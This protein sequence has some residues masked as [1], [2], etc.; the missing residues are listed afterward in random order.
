MQTHSQCTV[1]G[2]HISFS[3]ILKR[4]HKFSGL[5]V[6]PAKFRPRLSSVSAPERFCAPKTNLAK[7]HCNLNSNFSRQFVWQWKKVS[8][9]QN[10]NSIWPTNQLL[11]MNL[12]LNLIFSA[13]QSTCSRSPGAKCLLLMYCES[14]IEW[15]SPK[16]VPSS[17]QVLFK[18]D[19][20]DYIKNPLLDLKNSFC[21]EFLWIPS[22]AGRQN[23][24]V[25]FFLGFNLMK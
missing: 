17:V 8:F 14:A 19:K 24:K 15:F 21:F 6:I 18:V 7:I 9:D 1:K 23:Q 5:C 4:F 16:S 10:G 3:L 11:R 20:L 25:P 12:R 2:L 13:L 22:N